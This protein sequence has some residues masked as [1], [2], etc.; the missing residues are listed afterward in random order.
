MPYITTKRKAQKT[1]VTWLDL[2]MGDGEPDHHL[3]PTGT[4]TRFVDKINPKIIE[5]TDVDHLVRVLQDFCTKYEEILNGNV[6]KRY[7]TFYIPKNSGGLRRIDAP[8]EQ[9]KEAQR[10]LV[11]VLRR[12]FG[13]LYHTSAF[14][15]MKGRC[16]QKAVER[17]KNG[18]GNWYLKID[19]HNFFGSIDKKFVMRMLCLIYPFNLLMEKHSDVLSKALDICF[20]DGVL[21]QGS[22]A[23]P[24]LTNLI[25]IP[26]DHRLFNDFAARKFVY[27]RYADDIDI[28]CVQSFKYIEIV[29]Y[30]K[31]VIRDF[32]APFTINDKKTHYGSRRGQNWVLGL[33]VNGNNNITVGYQKKKQFKA[34]MNSFILDYLH[35]TK[36]PLDD[37]NHFGGLLSYYKS[38]EPDYFNYLIKHYNEKYKVNF[39]ATLK[40][41]RKQYN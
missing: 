18:E 1:Q 28:S 34:M 9:L 4:I 24:M 36:W 19:F 27:T 11:E 7:S 13:A 37:V 26:I 2:L 21:P 33:M 23:S 16:S 29:D 40:H 38:I 41:A 35:G 15:Y 17:H 32:G 31:K 6:D 10:E 20:L 22:V 3:D 14:A 39:N 25:M 12:D 8:D 5:A 30:V